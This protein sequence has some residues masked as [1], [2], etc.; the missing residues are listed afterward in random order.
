[1]LAARRGQNT[2]EFAVIVGILMVLTMGIVDF[3]HAIWDFNTIA[4]LA[5]EG[6]RY[7][8]APARTPAQIQSYVLTRA[9]LPGLATS[10]VTVTDR[11]TCGDVSDPIIVTLTYAYTPASP[12]LAVLVGSTVNL[13]ASANM[14]VE[15]GLNGTDCACGGSCT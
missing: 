15:Q 13:Q 2:V 5:R 14:Y 9:T 10:N 4:Y 6:A 12:M 1:V 11:G 7:G 3:S 8:V